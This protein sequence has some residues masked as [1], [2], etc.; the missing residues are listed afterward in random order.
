SSFY[1][2]AGYG[3]SAKCTED[4]KGPAV[5]RIP[6]IVAGR[7]ELDDLKFAVDDA[8]LGSDGQV[9]TGDFLFIRTNGSRSLIGRG[10]LVVHEPSDPLFFASYLIRLRLVTTD[11]CDRWFA[12]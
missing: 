2:D 3:T 6:N 1:W 8:A 12:L 4:A 7:I 5:L 10:A 9:R 11:A